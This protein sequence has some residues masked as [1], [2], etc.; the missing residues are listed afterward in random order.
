MSHTV[1]YVTKVLL[2][3]AVKLATCSAETR[4]IIQTTERLAKAFGYPNT[5]VVVAPTHIIVSVNTDNES[6]SLQKRIDA[7]GINMH[8]LNYLTN[9]CLLVEAKECTLE[10]LEKHLADIKHFAYHPLL[11]C[12]VIG[13]AT[14]SFAFLN[15]GGYQACL[16]G[17]FS[18]F[19]TMAFRLYLQ[20]KRLFLFFIFT[21][22]GFFA[23][24][25][26]LLINKYIYSLSEND[27]KVS[28]IVSVLLLVPG[29]PF[30]NGILDIFKGYSSMGVSRL[31]TAIILL[32]CVCVGI[33]MGFTL[34]H[35]EG[36]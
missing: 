15:G 23:T 9:L 36:W 10:E 22:C 33:V 12:F 19:F 25:I 1:N 30:I 34:F 32:A 16:V 35:M 3:F 24:A 4:L 2:N 31:F 27:L 7:I 6:S 8:N 14:L 21:M 18:G 26:T 20:S 5:E 17:F 28:L 13:M 29:F 11:M